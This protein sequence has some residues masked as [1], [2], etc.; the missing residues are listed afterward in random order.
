MGN[1]LG[2]MVHLV[3]QASSRVVTCIAKYCCNFTMWNY[4]NSLLKQCE[5]SALVEGSCEPPGMWSCTT[6]GE[7]RVHGHSFKSFGSLGP[8]VPAVR[9][10]FNMAQVSLE[11][12]V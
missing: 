10:V 9:H 2:G 4:T 11:G 12:R 1:S 5:L 8:G 7:A 3:I 6:P